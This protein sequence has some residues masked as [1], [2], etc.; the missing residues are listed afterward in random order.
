MTQEDYNE[1]AQANNTTQ[2]RDQFTGGDWIIERRNGKIFIEAINKE[3][4]ETTAVEIC[5]L[6]GNEK[7]DEADAALIADAKSLYYFANR[8]I[9]TCDERE[10][11]SGDFV[12]LQTAAK[13]ILNRINKPKN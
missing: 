3:G 11:L 10:K 9:N 7:I 5:Q 8:F 6:H 13:A 4:E 2:E 12:S 1:F